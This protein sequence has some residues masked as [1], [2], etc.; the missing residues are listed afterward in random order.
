MSEMCNLWISFLCT[1]TACWGSFL[2]CLRLS[3]REP[4]FVNE[5]KSIHHRI[6]RDSPPY[7]YPYACRRLS[8]LR[9]ITGAR[10]GDM[11]CGSDLAAGFFPES[12]RK[13]NDNL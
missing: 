11:I 1:F 2:V 10:C 8:C 7:T 13:D 6:K 9:D 3:T 5:S 12:S 4:A